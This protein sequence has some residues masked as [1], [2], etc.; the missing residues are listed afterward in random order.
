MALSKE[1]IN[2]LIVTAIVHL[3][4]II[5]LLC[6]EIGGAVM[7]ENSFLLDFSE[8]EKKES[9]ERQENLVRSAEEKLNEMLEAAGAE[10]IRNISVN[11]SELRDDRN[12]NASDLYKDAERLAQELKNGYSVEENE[13]D[14]AALSK[15]EKKEVKKAQYSGPSVLSWSLDGRR[16]SSLPVPAYKGY[17]AGE[18][19][20]FIYVNNAGKVTDAEIDKAHSCSDKSL[21]NFALEAAK[22][23]RFTSSSTAP[24]NQKGYIIYK[25]IAQ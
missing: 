18:V 23:S 25:F 13:E 5:V 9:L 16:A 10:P 21:W 6:N 2:G 20:V 8:H 4:V 11:R 17:N 14:Y 15:P 22:R 3:A 12:T 7:K 19:K 1:N 24:T